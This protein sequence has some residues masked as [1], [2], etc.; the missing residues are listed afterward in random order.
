MEARNKRPIQED[1]VITANELRSIFLFG[2]SLKD[3][4]GNEMSEKLLEFYIR[5]AQEWLETEIG[6][7][8]LCEREIEEQRDYRLTDYMTYNFIKLFRFPVQNVNQVS[9]Q[10][11][12]SQNL[13]TFDESWYRVESV[14]AHV[15]L[16]PTQG[17]FSSI[18]LS[19]GGS[20]IPLVYSGIEFVP[21][22]MY[23]KYR[24]GFKR[25]TIPAMIKELVGMKAAMGPLNLAG[26]LVAGA[27]IASKSLSIDGLSQSI[28]T[29]AS[30][31]NA[32]YG[33]RI[34]QYNKE[35]SS[36]LSVLRNYYHGINMVVA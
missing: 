11:P 33:A 14:G 17:T 29:T 25:G 23:V 6:G 10:F 2:V 28:G 27:G 32:G 9:I 35:I 8:V 36:R 21:H 12:L 7:L 4:D 30:A 18:I 34:L 5:S 15:N 13:L 3:D 19:Q 26:D 22:M 31:T 24:A 20:Y 1:L 16:F